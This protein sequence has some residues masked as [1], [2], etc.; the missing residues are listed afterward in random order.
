MEAI[1][2]NGQLCELEDGWAKTEIKKSFRQKDGVYISLNDKL[3]QTLKRRGFKEV[4][5][6]V[7]DL[8]KYINIPL[9]WIEKHAKIVER[10]FL[11]PENPLRLWEINLTLFLKGRS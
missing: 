10:V 3:L 7:V 4:S 6:H 9:N 2:I 11:Y 8:K 1:K 5:V